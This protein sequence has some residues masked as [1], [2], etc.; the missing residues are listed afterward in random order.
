MGK[1]ILSR[2]A[3]KACEAGSWLGQDVKD[4]QLCIGLLVLRL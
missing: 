4:A 2:R 1:A 3:V